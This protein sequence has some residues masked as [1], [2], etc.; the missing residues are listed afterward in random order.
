MKTGC[1]SALSS[2]AACDLNP[3]VWARRG[4]FPRE[5]GA[6]SH[7]ADPPIP[8]R[9]WAGLG[10]ERREQRLG[11]QKGRNTCP[12]ALQLRWVPAGALVL[13]ADPAHGLGPFQ[14]FCGPGQLTPQATHMTELGRDGGQEDPPHSVQVLL[15]VPSPCCLIRLTAVTTYR[16]AQHPRDTSCVPSERLGPP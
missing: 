9:V 11:A 8:V 2:C 7:T 6:W 13:R 16:R 14:H 10:R 1:L 15:T 4:S 5:D 12:R 3:S